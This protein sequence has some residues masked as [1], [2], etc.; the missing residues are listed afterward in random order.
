MARAAVARPLILVVGIVALAA[1]AVGF[2]KWREASRNGGQQVAEPFRIAGNFYYVGA[3]DVAAFLITTPQGHILLDGGYPGTPKLITASIAKLGFNVKDVKILINSE[4]HYDHA[5]GLAELQHASGAELWASDASADAIE[6]GGVEN[7]TFWLHVLMVRSGLVRYEPAHVQH[8][9]KDG[10]TIS[11]AGTTL[12]AHVTG[13][14]TKG[15]TSWTLPVRD[16]TRTLNVVSACS[17]VMLP[18]VRLIEPQRYPRIR[19]DFEHTFATLRALPADIWVTSHAKLFDRYKKFQARGTAPDSA[20]PF[21]D[22]A[23][24]RAYVDSGEAR[25]KRALAEQQR[26]N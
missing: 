15:C 11:L 21:V 7:G 6:T 23:G 5:G 10:D 18:G 4:P 3:N 20:A 19:E 13:G 14:H 24:Y 26:K 8:R 1:A 22:P 2:T 12:T 17:L 16:G 9:L 25:F